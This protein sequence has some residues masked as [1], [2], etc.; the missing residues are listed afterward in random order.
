MRVLVITGDK[1][2]GPGHPRYDLQQGAVDS[3]VVVYWG[4]SAL[5]PALPHEPFD[6]VTVQDPFWRGLFALTV[7]GRLRVRLNVQVH[8]DLAAQSFVKRMLARYVLRR[9]NSIRVVSHKIKNQIVARAPITVLPVY[10]EI[11]KYRNIVRRPDGE[12]ILWLGRFEEEKD[13]FYALEVLEAVR[14]KGVDAKLVML[15]TGSLRA[16]VRSAAAHLPVE[17]PGWSDPTF[18]FATCGVV[19][20]TSHAESYGASIIEALAAGVPVVA[21]DV[22]VAREAGATVV[23]KD[24]MPGVVAEALVHGKEASLKLPLF[25]RAEW[26]TTYRESLQ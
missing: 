26:Q 12:T 7:A 17:F 10:I 22:G 23:S 21:P 4:R 6:V 15:G 3:L 2:F 11:S 19:L 25:S 5:W 14:G 24:L 8:A 9:A 13:P 20:S 1:K 16:A 18:Y